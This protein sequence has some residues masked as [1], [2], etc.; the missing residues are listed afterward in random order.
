MA[1]LYA[2]D[3]RQISS[4]SDAPKMVAYLPNTKLL[5]ADMPGTVVAPVQELSDKPHDFLEWV[6]MLSRFVAG[7]VANEPRRARPSTRVAIDAT[8]AEN[9]LTAYVRYWTWLRLPPART[10][11]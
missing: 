8:P 4:Q 3:E 11:S 10:W 6:V 7:S 1:A 5:P 2:P 9:F